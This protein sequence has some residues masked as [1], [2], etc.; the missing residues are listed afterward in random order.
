MLRKNKKISLSV[1]STLLLVLAPCL[2]QAKIFQTQFIKFD[3][4]A[5]WKCV[6]I[7]RAWVCKSTKKIE[8]KEAFYVLAAKAIGPEDTRENLVR[9]LSSPKNI[10]NSDNT[11]VFSIVLNKGDKKLRDTN[12]FSSTHMNSELMDYKS[13][14]YST[15]T[16]SLSILFSMHVNKKY[17]IKYQSSVNTTEAS[18]QL[19]AFKLRQSLTRSS[20]GNSEGFDP[21]A[22][23]KKKLPI[24][25]IAGGVMALLAGL[26]LYKSFK[27]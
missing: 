9:Q 11:P 7:Q 21:D 24:V 14:Y 27:D 17:L 4:P 6:K 16:G 18:L 13:T 15:L 12:W 1:L 2:L 22:N 5:N 23:P 20:G 25:P 3:I 26:I 19:K 10:K 8:N